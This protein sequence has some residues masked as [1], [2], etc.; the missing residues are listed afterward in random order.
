[1]SSLHVSLFARSTS[2][3]AL[4]NEVTPAVTTISRNTSQITI[5]HTSDLKTERPFICS[6]DE[7]ETIDT[8]RIPETLDSPQSHLSS[9]SKDSCMSSAT[10]SLLMNELSETE[11]PVVVYDTKQ[12]LKVC[13]LDSEAANLRGSEVLKLSMKEYIESQHEKEKRA[14]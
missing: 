14:K 9:L 6:S 11:L 3:K 13:I 2:L 7:A 5:G 1:M 12:K 4:C 10:Y 8:T